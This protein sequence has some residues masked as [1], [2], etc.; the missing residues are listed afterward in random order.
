MNKKIIAAA[1]L[2]GAISLP[3]PPANAQPSEAPSNNKG[4]GLDELL[5]AMRSVN[6]GN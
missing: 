6:R 3:L 2:V 5:D 1:L 4:I